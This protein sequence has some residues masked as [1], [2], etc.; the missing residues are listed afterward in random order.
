[1]AAWRDRGRTLR[2]HA[3]VHPHRA[4]QSRP[5]ALALLRLRRTLCLR[6]WAR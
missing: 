2:V 5:R 1:M 6:A 3:R 4:D